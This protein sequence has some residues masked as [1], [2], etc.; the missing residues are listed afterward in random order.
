MACRESSF[1]GIQI[2]Y[3]FVNN[4]GCQGEE[5]EKWWVRLGFHNTSFE[6]AYDHVDG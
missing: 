1:R 4:C 6:K 3:V 5:K 2:F